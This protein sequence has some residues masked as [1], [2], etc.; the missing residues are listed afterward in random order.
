MDEFSGYEWDE[1]KRRANIVKHGLDFAD[2]VEV[3]DDQKQF[4]YRSPH[5]SEERYVSIGMA[6]ER[7]IAVVFTRRA[8]KIRIISARPA[9]RIEREQYD[10]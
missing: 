9:R 7:L 6:N 3:F 1:R 4:A 2:A 8:A 10:R 5:P